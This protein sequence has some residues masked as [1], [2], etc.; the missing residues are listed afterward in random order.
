MT[1]FHVHIG[2]FNT[3]YY[4]ADRVFSALK[5]YGTDEVY[6]SSTTSCMYFKECSALTDKPDLQARAPF[7]KDLYEGIKEEVNNAL[8]AATEIGI[9][10][11]ALYWCVPEMHKALELSFCD[12]M[13]ALPYKGFKIH[14]LAQNWDFDDA[15]TAT[16]AEELF[17]YAEQNEVRILIHCGEDVSC[18]PLLFEKQIA[19]HPNVVVQLAH[20]RPVDDT[21]YMLK[22]YP[23]TC[24]DMSFAPDHAVELIKNAGYSDRLLFGTDFPI[25]HYRMMDPKEDPT[26]KALIDFLRN[27]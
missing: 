12:V 21:L 11:H 8:A 19:A 10:A 5:A 9:K 16:L 20:T 27:K 6:F 22:K 4:Y 23:N 13:K 14:P 17:S 26:E 7:A 25:T 15:Y 2:Q 3:V 24:C 18:S 1:D